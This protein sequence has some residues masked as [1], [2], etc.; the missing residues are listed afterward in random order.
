MSVPGWFMQTAV[1]VK[2]MLHVTH[3]GLQL[4]YPKIVYNRVAGVCTSINSEQDIMQNFYLTF[5][6]VVERMRSD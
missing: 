1:E 2:Y 3:L 4:R 6:F 5:F